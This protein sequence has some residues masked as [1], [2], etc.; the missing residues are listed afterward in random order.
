MSAFKEWLCFLGCLNVELFRLSDQRQFITV[1][2]FSSQISTVNWFF[3]GRSWRQ[4]PWLIIL[5]HNF[6]T[7]SASCGLEDFPPPLSCSPCETTDGATDRES[8]PGNWHGAPHLRRR[9]GLGCCTRVSELIP[10]VLESGR[11]GCEVLCPESQ[12]YH[13]VRNPFERFRVFL[14]LFS[15]FEF[16]V[17]RCENYLFERFEFLVCSK[18]NHKQ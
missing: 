18:F 17:R 2:Q 1:L 4:P 3:S 13:S 11:I 10:S 5:F 9:L 7:C 8:F 6:P 15:R 14:K 16:D 12:S